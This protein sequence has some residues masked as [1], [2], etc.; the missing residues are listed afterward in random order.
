[1]GTLIYLPFFIADCTENTNFAAD[2]LTSGK[3]WLLATTQ[4]NAETAII[5]LTYYPLD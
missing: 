5:P 3:I 2:L 1:M 4:K